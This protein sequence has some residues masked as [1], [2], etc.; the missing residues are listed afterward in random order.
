[1]IIWKYLL[2]SSKLPTAPATLIMALNV[3]TSA[4]A[5][6]STSSSPNTSS[7]TYIAPA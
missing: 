7:H 5:T 1:M 4:L 2:A 3:T 6:P